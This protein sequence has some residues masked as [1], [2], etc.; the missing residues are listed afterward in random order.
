MTDR[1][2]E[3]E[4]LNLDSV[5]L[6]ELEE[7]LELAIDLGGGGCNPNSCPDNTV[8]CGCNSDYGWRC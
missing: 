2:D 4:C 5:D 3:M 6:V 7:R 8:T 1:N